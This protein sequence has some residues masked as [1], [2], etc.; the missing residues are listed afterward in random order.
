MQLSQ[1]LLSPVVENWFN[2][3][4]VMQKIEDIIPLCTIYRL[5][6]SADKPSY[7]ITVN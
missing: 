5:Q 7:V 2:H 6:M 1:T 3:Y 4:C